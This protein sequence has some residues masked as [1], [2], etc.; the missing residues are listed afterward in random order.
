MRRQH[1]VVF[2][3][4]TLLALSGFTC[5]RKRPIRDE[6]ES[7][8]SDPKVTLAFAYPPGTFEAIFDQSFRG[9]TEVHARGKTQKV[10]VD[11]TT[12][13]WCQMDVGQPEADGSY[14]CAVRFTRMQMQTR[15]PQST[16]IDSDDAASL[17]GNP[18]AKMVG[19]LLKSAITV[20]FDKEG[21]PVKV[22]GFE[23]LWTEIAGGSP[24]EREVAESMKKQFSDAAFGKM[25]E[26]ARAYAPPGPVGK[27]AVWYPKVT[28]PV[29]I[30]GDMSFEAKCRLTELD[31]TTEGQVATVAMAGV[32]AAGD[33]KPVTM[34]PATMNIDAM[35][36]A[37]DGSMRVDV[38][39]GLVRESTFDTKGTVEMSVSAQGNTMTMEMAIEGTSKTTIRP[40]P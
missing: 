19:P 10:P 11:Q 18:M 1:A 36:L 5:S 40:R 23:A 34:G 8:G 37:L 25:F 30:V 21:K 3:L 4:V 22:G 14:D 35:D 17:H 15:Q 31:D 28:I 32:I 33:A 2:L 27:G 7:T 13:Y 38:K 9:D 26:G 16:T 6:P 20:H 24:Q 29:P 39:T 12:K